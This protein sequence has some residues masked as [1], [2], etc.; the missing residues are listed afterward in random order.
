MSKTAKFDVSIWYNEKSRHIHIAGGG[1]RSTVNA[2]PESK[3]YHPNLFKKLARVL[4]E[5]GKPAPT[6]N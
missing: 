2:D 4:R 3:R 1:F 6:E 5:Q